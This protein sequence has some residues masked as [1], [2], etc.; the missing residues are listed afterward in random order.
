MEEWAKYAESETAISIIEKDPIVKQKAKKKESIPKLAL[1]SGTSGEN[2]KEKGKSGGV[3]KNRERALPEPASLLSDG[4]LKVAWE[5]LSRVIKQLSG[6]T[7]SY[8]WKR[9]AIPVKIKIEEYLK[10]RKIIV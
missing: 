3:K 6:K 5:A 2:A 7:R 8:D 9:G 1:T 10:K 4:E